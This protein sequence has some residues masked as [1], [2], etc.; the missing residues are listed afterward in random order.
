[1]KQHLQKFFIH[2]DL[3]AETPVYLALLPPQTKSP[4]GKL[5]FEKKIVPFVKGNCREEMPPD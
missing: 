5:L 2:L 3:G 4:N 1:L